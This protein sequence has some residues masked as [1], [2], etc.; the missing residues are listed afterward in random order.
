MVQHPRLLF[1]GAM[2]GILVMGLAGWWVG[3][4]GQPLPTAPEV[5]APEAP[6]AV[7]A[8]LKADWSSTSNPN[9]RPAGTWSY[10]LDS[11]PLVA[12]EHWSG[13]DVSGWGPAANRTGDFLPFMGQAKTNGELQQYL[14]NDLK[15]GDIIVHTVDPFNG[16]REGSATIAFKSAISGTA[17]VTGRLWPTRNL[18][19]QNNWQVLLRAEGAVRKLGA[20]SLPEGEG[21]T[22]ETPAK[23]DLATFHIL[24]DDT[25]QLVLAR[26]PTSMYGDFTAVDLTIAITPDAG[27]TVPATV[28]PTAGRAVAQGSNGYVLLSFVFSFIALLLAVLTFAGVVVLLMRQRSSPRG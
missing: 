10:N 9:V 25:L 28:T 24:K 22:R 6:P 13:G 8:D 3:T 26:D 23:I 20:G 18:S 17:L 12:V 11:T 19:R 16:A 5:A 4:L 7:V 1:G 15:N 27:G 14:G 21:L 2:I